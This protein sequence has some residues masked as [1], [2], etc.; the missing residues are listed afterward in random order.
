MAPE[1]T[2]LGAG[3]IESGDVARLS[4]QSSEGG[5]RGD[6]CDSSSGSEAGTGTGNG[7]DAKAGTG[8]GKFGEPLGTDGRA[9]SD[10][11]NVEADAETVLVLVTV[12]AVGAAV[13]AAVAEAVTAVLRS[14]FVGFEG[15][16]G[17]TTAS[18]HVNN[19]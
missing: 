12:A 3:A 11:G 5:T 1:D 16:A 2:S 4:L 18:V 8:A 6:A 17:A 14:F 15:I 19:P 10:A 9:A 13:A 7:V